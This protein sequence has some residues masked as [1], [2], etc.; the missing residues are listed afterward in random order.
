MPRQ[1]RNYKK[2]KPFRDASYKLIVGEGLTEVQYFEG[3]I[4]II[5][6]KD[7]RKYKIKVYPFP[8]DGRTVPKYLIANAIAFRETFSDFRKDMDEL[9]VLVDK[10]LNND[11]VLNEAVNDCKTEKINL[12]VSTPCFELWLLLHISDLSRLHFDIN[13]IFN[14]KPNRIAAQNCEKELR[15]VLGAYNKSRLPLD[16]FLPHTDT[17]I[18]RAKAIDNGAA[19][20]WPTEI[21]TR[22]YK[23]IENIQFK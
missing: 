23:L 10:D 16:E 22:V 12:A 8:A 1:N 21:G 6:K 2:N 15:K 20:K 4:S 18:E 9:W 19:D 13:P 5:D 7:R 17:A 11:G 3:L 14:N